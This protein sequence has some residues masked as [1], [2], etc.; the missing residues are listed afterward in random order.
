MWCFVKRASITTNIPLPQIVYQKDN[1]IR[2]A[3]AKRTCMGREPQ[4]ASKGDLA[5]GNKCL[6]VHV[7]LFTKLNLK[8]AK[9]KMH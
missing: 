7:G 8:N 5:K 2:L 4:K 9:Q 3:F 1:D 6:C